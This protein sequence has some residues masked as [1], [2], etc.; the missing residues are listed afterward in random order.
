MCIRDRSNT[1]EKS[2]ITGAVGY[3][4]SLYYDGVKKFQ[5]TGV[6]VSVY[7]G[8]QDKDGD[9]GT[10]GQVLSSTGTGLDWVDA[11]VGSVTTIDVKQDNYSSVHDSPLNPITVTPTSVGV[12]TVSVGSSSNAYGRRYVQ[13]NDPTSV[14]GGSYTVC[15]G[16]IWYDTST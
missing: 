6:G 13:V 4:V 1:G 3:G 2:Y 16:D 15:D 10:L 11:A 5:I 9:L 14:S 12:T 8:L 7:G